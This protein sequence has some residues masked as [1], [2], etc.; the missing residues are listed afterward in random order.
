MS[1]HLE[2]LIFRG[3]KAANSLL[4]VNSIDES[5]LLIIGSMEKVVDLLFQLV[6]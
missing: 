1:V 4:I 2:E 5:Q 3:G 6:I